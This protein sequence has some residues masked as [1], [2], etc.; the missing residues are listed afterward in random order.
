MFDNFEP[1][2]GVRKQ[3]LTFQPSR[4]EI[5][6]GGKMVNSGKTNHFI[7]AKVI[8]I[9]GTEK[10]EVNFDDKTLHNELAQSNIF[11]EFITAN[12]RLQLIIVPLQTNVQ[13]MGIMAFQTI[14]GHTRPSKNFNRNE[15]YCCNL[16][17]I[18]GIIAKV[19]FSYSNPEKLLE[20][21]A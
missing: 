10:M 8:N 21:Y 17:I 15:P 16:F 1:F 13:N 14:L 11:D 7:N 4:Y 9:D 5:W 18:Q 3:N 6:I 19:T 12:D 20:F 2:Q